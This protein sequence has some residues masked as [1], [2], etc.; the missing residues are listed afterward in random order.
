M[1]RHSFA[2]VLATLSFAPVAGWAA[3]ARNPPTAQGIKDEA[4]K[5]DGLS[6]ALG[7]IDPD[8][9]RAPIDASSWDRV[10]VELRP[11]NLGEMPAAERD[12]SV[13]PNLRPQYLVLT[14]K[15]RTDL[16]VMVSMVNGTDV[17]RKVITAGETNVVV[18]DV[19]PVQKVG[20]WDMRIEWRNRLP[21]GQPRSAF[22]NA[23]LTG[24]PEEKVLLE[25]QKQAL[26]EANAKAQETM[27]KQAEAFKVAEKARHAAET[28]QAKVDA[29]DLATLKTTL[30]P[31]IGKWMPYTRIDYRPDGTSDSDFRAI[32][33]DRLSDGKGLATLLLGSDVASQ[34]GQVSV[35]L[36]NGTLN[37]KDENC[38]VKMRPARD[39]GRV[40][41]LFGTRECYSIH[42]Q[43][44]I[45]PEERDLDKLDLRK[46]KGVNIVPD[47]AQ[48]TSGDTAA[49]PRK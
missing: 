10:D 35:S 23:V 47:T 15:A 49:A 32:K 11:V 38:P 9:M 22:K 1:R 29:E 46:M 28:A 45:I 26:E 43:I 4:L 16:Y 5:S 6:K 14:Y 42:Q 7:K 30:D 12:P 36:E 13:D 8:P 31:L 41:M 37:F 24:S 25:K 27:A 21:S 19:T 44:A 48:A 40:Y 39:K 3:E 18:A 20:G 2:L 33:I 34:R 17:I